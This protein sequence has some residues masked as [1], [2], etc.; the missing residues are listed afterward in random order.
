MKRSVFLVRVNVG[1]F[2]ILFLCMLTAGC[3]RNLDD[4]TEF[5]SRVSNAPVIEYVVQFS[6]HL[7]GAPAWEQPRTIDYIFVRNDADARL[8]YFYRIEEAGG[9]V[10][11]YFPGHYVE[12]RPEDKSALLFSF[13]NDSSYF[14]AV[15]T[16]PL[17]E[18][19]LP[20]VL[21]RFE[22][23][24]NS[25]E[26]IDRMS[27]TLIGD[28]DISRFGINIL[29]TSEFVTGQVRYE[30]WINHK[31]K[32]PFSYS[33]HLTDYLGVSVKR[34][35]RTYRFTHFTTDATP[36]K[37]LDLSSLPAGFSVNE[38][39]PDLTYGVTIF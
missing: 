2:F 35:Q 11:M 7:N 4:L 6:N 24:L 1:A 13:I 8:P 27:D 29:D 15:L 19:S 20:L 34:E 22:Q 9:N 3:R 38:Y 12:T 26:K 28:A 5:T 18:H 39:H 30:L 21:S 23:G 33:V 17:L 31:T 32:A 14:R 10:G 36:S 25:P 37:P 16:F